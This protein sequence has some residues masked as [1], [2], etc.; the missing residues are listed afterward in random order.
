MEISLI[1]MKKKN[2]FLLLFFEK[3]H[4]VEQ[5]SIMLI[6]FRKF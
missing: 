1:F 4:L 2:S 6:F 5:F 3:M